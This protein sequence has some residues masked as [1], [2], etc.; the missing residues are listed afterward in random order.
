MKNKLIPIVLVLAAGFAAYF[1]WKPTGQP[2]QSKTIG[3]ILPLTGEAS[4]YGVAIRNGIELAAKQSKESG[5]PDIKLVY[6]DD[7]GSPSKAATA[8]QHMLDTESPIAV[9]GGA[10]SS[11]A[12]S[13]IP[14]FNQRKTVLLSPTATK[15]SLTAEGSYFFRLWPSDNYD[16]KFMADAA[17][18]KLKIK[19]V[20]II[21]INTAYGKGITDVFVREYEQ[22]GGKIVLNEG[23]EQGAADFRALLE[24]LKAVNAEAVFLPGYVAEISRL[25]VQAKE[26]GVT[27]RILG[28]NSLYDQ[29]L[30]ELAGASAEGAVFSY[31]EFDPSSSSP[32][33]SKFVTDYTAAYKSSPDAF[34]AQGFDAFGILAVAVQRGEFSREKLLGLPTWKGPGGNVKFL[35]TGDVEKPLRLIWIKRGKFADMP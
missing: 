17:W 21:Y 14:L 6:A 8:A 10:M 1:V 13:I 18:K 16:G 35:P 26:A 28:V 33:I 24:K 23:Y 2:Q 32:A 4:V 29:K 11:T 20:G 30:I 31:P 25:V 3:V 7:Q 27:S 9:I 15:A 12:E 34:A 19:T 5:G 22:M